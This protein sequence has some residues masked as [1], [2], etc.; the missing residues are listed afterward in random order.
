[1]NIRDLLLKFDITTD[2][3]W[4]GNFDAFDFQD[5][6]DGVIEDSGRFLFTG[7]TDVGVELGLLIDTDDKFNFLTYTMDGEGFSHYEVYSVD[8]VFIGSF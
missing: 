8:G 5:V 1:M 2:F 4:L 7:V 6:F 3:K